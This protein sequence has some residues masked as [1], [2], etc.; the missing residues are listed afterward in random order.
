MSKDSMSNSEKQKQ[1]KCMAS[2]GDSGLPP[3]NSTLLEDLVPTEKIMYTVHQ[4]TIK[5]SKGTG[6]NGFS[7]LIA[8]D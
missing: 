4:F 7:D 8:F 3:Q 6:I 1:E 2:K 5:C